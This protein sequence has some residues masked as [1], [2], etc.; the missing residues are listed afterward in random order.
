M[1]R[2]T[3]EHLVG[4][5]SAYMVMD[6]EA[7][8]VLGVYATPGEAETVSLIYAKLQE[9]RDAAIYQAAAQ[10]AYHPDYP[11]EQDFLY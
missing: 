11:E 1:A 7:D 5:P 6:T 3:V 2:Y 8:R 9:R 10:R 4:S